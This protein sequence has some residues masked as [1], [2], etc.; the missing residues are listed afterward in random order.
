[1]QV[2]E[3]V[4]L[5]A[6]AEI[7]EVWK[8]DQ[9]GRV[10]CV[11]T[12]SGLFVRR[13]AC[14]SAIPLS[15]WL[16]RRFL[17]R[18]RAALLAAEG[19]CGIPRWC[20]GPS[21]PSEGWRTHIEGVPLSRTEWLPADFF[22]L[23]EELVADLHARGICHNDLHKEQN[24]LV[25]PGG[26]PRLIDFQLASVHAQRG[27]VF[28]TRAREDLRHI[29]KHRRRYTRKGRGPGGVE[30]QGA[31][32]GLRRSWVALAWRR[33]GKPVYHLITRGL[34]RT[35]DGEARRAETQ[36]FPRFGPPLRECRR[37]RSSDA[38]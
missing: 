36:A 18:E 31:G 35:R 38:S 37:D 22:D 1:M 34:L 33:L 20:A 25:D 21:T 6:P 8:S 30:Q 3:S 4:P 29:E 27:R 7:V 28:E 26:W 16:A 10:E 5:K 11:R 23:L 12:D 32:A 14:G 15:G 19:Q 13:V 2:A 24:I 9:F 17:A